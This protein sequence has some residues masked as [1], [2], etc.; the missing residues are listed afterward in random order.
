M[1]FC[2]GYPVV[3]EGLGKAARG[4]VR[5]KAL[6][7]PRTHVVNDPSAADCA[8]GKTGLASR[9]APL[10][11]LSR[12]QFRNRADGGANASTCG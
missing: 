12:R 3:R 6:A 5:G 7:S 4:D 9:A 8:K 2:A 11:R 1:D 10:V